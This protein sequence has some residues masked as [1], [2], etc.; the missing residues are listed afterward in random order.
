MDTSKQQFVCDACNCID[1]V[2][3][4]FPD[5]LPIEEPE[6]LCSLCQPDGTWHE[7]FPRVVYDPDRDMVVNRPT[8]LGLG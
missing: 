8:G 2:E 7:L 5:G 4:A 3:L 1:L 6:H